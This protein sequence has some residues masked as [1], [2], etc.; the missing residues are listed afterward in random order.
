MS[1][2]LWVFLAA[3]AGGLVSIATTIVTQRHMMN[4]ESVAREVAALHEL[5]NALADWYMSFVQTT[6]SRDD[7]PAVA[8]FR[9]GV[10]QELRVLMLVERVHDSELRAAVNDLLIREAEV[11]S[12]DALQLGRDELKELLAPLMQ[13]W[14]PIQRQIGARLRKLE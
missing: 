13:L 4:R 3:V 6:N 5:Q 9:R 2:G 8:D 14:P 12:E 10:H 7:G 11:V 1:Q